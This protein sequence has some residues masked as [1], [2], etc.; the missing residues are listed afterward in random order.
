MQSI[1]W[2]EQSHYL[3][4]CRVTVSLLHVALC[5][6]AYAYMHRRCVA[7]R[8]L[9]RAGELFSALIN[10][11][12]FAKFLGWVVT[13]TILLTPFAVI[14]LLKLITM[15]E[16]YD[17]FGVLEPNLSWSGRNA[18]TLLGDFLIVV[19][20]GGC[21]AILDVLI[22][23]PW[24]R[25]RRKATRQ[26]PVAD[27]MGQ[28]SKKEALKSFR[29]RVAGSAAY[30]LC[31]RAVAACL[32]VAG[33]Y[34]FTANAHMER[35][36]RREPMPESPRRDAILALAKEAKVSGL[37][38]NVRRDVQEMN[39]WATHNDE[40][41]RLEFSAP[42]WNNLSDK[43]F[44]A[45]AGH[46]LVHVVRGN[47]YSTLAELCIYL[48]IV[49]CV[50]LIF[51]FGP[52]RK[53]GVLHFN[54]LTR[55]PIYV[56]IFIALWPCLQA[57]QCAIKRPAEDDADRFGVAALVGKKLITAE[58]MKQALI[59]GDRFNLTDPDPNLLSWLFIYDHPPLVERL[60]AVDEAAKQASVETAGK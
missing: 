52:P 46:E 58:D 32:I 26:P 15:R 38:L 8:V 23:L 22:C 2:V 13:A 56:V 11:R 40:Q 10:N 37:D 28:H 43:Q 14:T 44:L 48:T 16:L 53:E 24:K 59:E 36:A 29:R 57:V 19:L 55:I 6:A 18:L 54:P 3:M 27:A 33:M 30:H 25:S 45:V 20:I 21:Q 5:V 41:A 35:A 50:L 49:S 4:N 1:Q 7:A 42:L 31:F 17:H 60:R 47:F 34:F 12:R 9:A 51:M 39:A